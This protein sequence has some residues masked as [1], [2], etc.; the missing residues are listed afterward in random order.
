[1]AVR[2]VI[3]EQSRAGSCILKTLGKDFSIGRNLDGTL[4]YRGM[5]RTS[6]AAHT[7]LGRPLPI[8][9]MPLLRLLRPRL[10]KQAE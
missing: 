3:E 1:M 7:R 10:L 9:V 8:R 2:E 6:D 4:D 5:S